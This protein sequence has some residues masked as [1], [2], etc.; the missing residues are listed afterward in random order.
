MSTRLRAHVRQNVVGY[1]AIFLFAIG[2]TAFATHGQPDT[3]STG[4]IID[5]EVQSVDMRNNTIRT[6]DVRNDTFAG[7]GLIAEDLAPSSVGSSEIGDGQ[8]GTNDLVN[9]AVSSG[10]LGSNAVTTSK[11]STAFAKHVTLADGQR[12][13]NPDGSTTGFNIDDADLNDVA[14]DFIVLQLNDLGAVTTNAI[15][16]VTDIAITGDFDM[17]CNVAPPNGIELHYLLMTVQP[18]T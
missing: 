3:I 4:D 10:K 18:D 16:G 9:N 5:N 13:W 6:D 12:G 14:F 8:V 11:V 1:V 7:G 2:G 17:D 15:C